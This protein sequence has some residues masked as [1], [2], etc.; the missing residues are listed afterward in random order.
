MIILT[1]R[2]RWF[3]NTRREH[4]TVISLG[5]PSMNELTG[6]ITDRGRRTPRRVHERGQ[7]TQNEHRWALFGNRPEDTYDVVR[8][9]QDR[10]LSGFLNEIWPP[11]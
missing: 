1:L 9:F 10:E 8:S 6:I 2:H 5:P 7:I 3:L 11:H 4:P